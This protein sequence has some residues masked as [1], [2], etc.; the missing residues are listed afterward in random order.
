[1]YK[2]GDIVKIRSDLEVGRDYGGC[3][4]VSKMLPKLGTKVKIIGYGYNLKKQPRFAVENC[5]LWLSIEM[6]ES[7]KP[8]LFKLL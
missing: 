2:K 3:A 5:T 6:F 7:V 8:K 4:F 1:M